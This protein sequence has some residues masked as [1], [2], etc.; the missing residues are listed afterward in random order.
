MNIK[1]YQCVNKVVHQG[2]RVVLYVGVG[3][4][5]S[6]ICLLCYSLMLTNSSH[7]AFISAHSAHIMLKNPNCITGQEN[8]YS[9]FFSLLKSLICSYIY[10]Y[11]WDDIIIIIIGLYTQ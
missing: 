7:Y 1:V 11:I 6:Q 8:N 4:L 9:N 2:V 3:G 5:C 10:N